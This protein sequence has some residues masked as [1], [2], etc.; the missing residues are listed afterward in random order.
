MSIE[1]ITARI[2]QEAKD[3]AEHLKK[4]A[5]AEKDTLLAKAAEEAEA[6]KKETAA[7]AVEDAKV[8]G[9]RR[10]SVAELEARKAQYAYYRDKLL[11]FDN[12]EMQRERE[13]F[14]G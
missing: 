10:N 6:V 2:L 5:E 14:N 7:K 1:S 4:Q 3:E 11:A 9:E 13:S 8:L 12:I